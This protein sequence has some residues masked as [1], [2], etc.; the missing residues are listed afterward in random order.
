MVLRW[1]LAAS[2]A[3][4]LDSFDAPVGVGAELAQLWSGHHASARLH[5]M[6]QKLRSDAVD[7]KALDA[8]DD[9]GAE[10]AHLFHPNH[11]S[12]KLKALERKWDSEAEYEHPHR[13][14][15]PVSIGHHDAPPASFVETQAKA[16]P[17]L[18]QTK[19]TEQAKSHLAGASLADRA[20]PMSIPNRLE[21]L[22]R[23]SGMRCWANEGGKLRCAPKAKTERMAAPPS[24]FAQVDGDE[25]QRRLKQV[26]EKHR[27][28][29]DCRIEGGEIKCLP[30]GSTGHASSYLQTGEEGL[31]KLQNMRHVGVGSQGGLEN[32]RQPLASS[33]GWRR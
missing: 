6:E 32:L 26:Q 14:G 7:P 18:M 12:S 5:N 33:W 19:A 16:A 11:R 3:V 24:S 9:V 4:T 21:R 2:A 30:K 31:S 22:E 17:T 29:L 27:D 23:T 8:P 28:T 25:L 20:N 10:L 13:H 15:H 1:L